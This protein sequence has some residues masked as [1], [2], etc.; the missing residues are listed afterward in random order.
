[1]GV[2]ATIS[3]GRRPAWLERRVFGLDAWLRRRQAILEYSTEPRCLF[4]LKVVQ[5]KEAVELADGTSIRPGERVVELH[6]WNEHVPP[7][8]GDRPSLSWARKVDRD[9]ELSLHELA[10]FL[11]GDRDYDGI[12]AIRGDMALGAPERSSQLGWMAKRLGFEPVATSRPHDFSSLLRRLG[13]NI[14]ITLLVL[15]QNPG[16][17]RTDVLRRGRTLAYISRAELMRRYLPPPRGC[18]PSQ[19]LSAR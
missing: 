9:F 3:D 8:E 14:L 2:E 4:R 6:L 15:A 10:R 13:E 19:A 18:G 1:V 11:A 7:F 16:A 12:H 5:A 17:F